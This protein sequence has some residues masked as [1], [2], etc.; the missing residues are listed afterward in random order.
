MFSV[1]QVYL[2]RLKFCVVCINGRRYGCCSECNVVSDDCNGPTS[3][4]VQPIGTH[5]GEVMY[6]WCVSFRRDLGFL[7]CDDISMCVV[8][9][10][11]ELLSFIIDSFYVY[12]QY[13]RILAFLLLGRCPC[14]VSVVGWS[15]LVCR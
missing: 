6:F 1:V 4:F 5:S 10:Q 12:L 15:S 2:D 3:S 14:G 7:N 9:K 13:E 11:F 8:N